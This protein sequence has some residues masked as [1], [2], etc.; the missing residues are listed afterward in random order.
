[1]KKFLIKTTLFVLFGVVSSY[2]LLLLLHHLIQNDDFYKIDKETSVIIVGDSH[3]ETAYNDSLIP[4][5]QN[6]GQS[7]DSYFYTYLKTKKLVENNPQ[8]NTVLIEFNNGQILPTIN[9]SIWDD[10]HINSKFPKY[11]SVMDSEDYGLLIK[12]N[13]KGVLNGKA[14]S[15]NND[16]ELFQQIEN[17]S[18]N[19]F[20]WGKY[21]KLTNDGSE[22]IEKLE[23]CLVND[24]QYSSYT[25]NHVNAKQMFDSYLFFHNHGVDME[26]SRQ[27]QMEPKQYT[28]QVIF[29]K[30]QRENELSQISYTNFSYL[31]K[32]IHFCKQNDVNVKL[33]RT[34][35]HHTYPGDI[36]EPTFQ[37]ILK[38]YLSDLSFLDFKNYPIANEGF[39]DYH[40]LNY[41]GAKA[42]SEFFASFIESEDYMLKR[43]VYSTK[44]LNP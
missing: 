7:S 13:L 29:S 20:D 14:L 35:V 5:F 34:P 25:I 19:D 18:F 33:I 6:F 8:I 38:N 32:T 36:N 28:V 41:K 22:K 23:N 12:H 4:G 44:N 24:A 39:A 42:F 30:K 40:H 17:P 21:K 27:H 16:L 31:M 9:Q 10:K 2:G 37:A 3:P 26:I 43:Y 11:S 15:I 1:M